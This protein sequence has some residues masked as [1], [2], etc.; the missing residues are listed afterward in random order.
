MPIGPVT[1]PPREISVAEPVSPA[2]ERVKRVLFQP[3]DLGKWFTIG[4][5]AWLAQ[6]GEGGFRGNYN[7]GQHHGT[8]SG[9]NFHRDFDR[10]REYVLDNLN[11]I[12]PL[13]AGL[14]VIGLALW[15]LFLWLNSRG[16]FMFL[17][18]VA[19][20]KA[21]VAEP[22]HKFAYEGNS[23]FLF[24]AGARAGG[25]DLYTAVAYHCHRHRQQNVSQRPLFAAWHHQRDRFWDFIFCLSDRV[26][27]H[28][29]TDIGFR[30][31]HHVSA[32]PPLSVSL[33]GIGSLDI[34]PRGSFHPVFSVPDCAGAGHRR[35]CLQRGDYHVLPRRMPDD[36]S[37]RGHG[38]VVAG[39]D[40]QTLLL[41]LF[42]GPVRPGVRRVP[43]RTSTSTRC[44]AVDVIGASN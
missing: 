16:K 32:P 25:N 13:A 22:W 39:L 21:E 3:F 30:G 35:D 41:A 12:V 37:L 26:C 40:V 33:E 28:P 44:A 24:R 15:L 23:L 38:S 29:K 2:L 36:A 1:T 34:G 8:N 5:C 17:H 7:F 31:A 43:A 14:V 27:H 18:C 6:L 4:F 11:W 10:A 42:S 9:E 19:L 20:D